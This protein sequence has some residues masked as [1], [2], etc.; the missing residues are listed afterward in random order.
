MRPI[1]AS[2]ATNAGQS[3]RSINLGHPAG[4]PVWVGN[5]TGAAINQSHARDGKAPPGREDKATAAPR[6]IGACRVGSERF[7]LHFTEFD[8]TLVVGDA[9]L[10]L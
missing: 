10:V 6:L 1:G 8:D 7:D 2:R 9:F 5:G 4:V 3:E